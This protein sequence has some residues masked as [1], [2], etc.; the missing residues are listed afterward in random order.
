MADSEATGENAPN[1]PSGPKAKLPGGLGVAHGSQQANHLPDP[2][3]DT[4]S[5]RIS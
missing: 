4:F 3:S 5:Q 1:G 2:G